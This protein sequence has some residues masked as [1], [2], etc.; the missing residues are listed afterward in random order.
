MHPYIV[1]MMARENQRRFS[2]EIESLHVQSLIKKSRPGLNRRLLL[3]FGELLIH[4]GEWMKRRCEPFAPPAV[5][6]H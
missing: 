5:E 6:A 3:T 4:I 1:E 2:E